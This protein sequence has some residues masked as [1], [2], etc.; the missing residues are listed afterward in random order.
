MGAYQIVRRFPGGGSSDLYLASSSG[1]R[2][3]CLLKTIAPARGDTDGILREGGILLRLSHPNVVRALE[4]GRADDTL[5]LALEHV[6][7]KDLAAVA[8]R[9]KAQGRVLS[10]PA[11]LAIVAS[12]CR[13]LAHVH[14][15][16]F[17]HRDVAPSNLLLAYDGETK[18]CDFGLSTTVTDPE[19][20]RRLI[21]HLGYLAP[22]I[23]RGEAVSPRSDLF[24]V[25]A[26][27]WELLT[28]QSRLP[29]VSARDVTRFARLRNPRFIAPSSLRSEVPAALDR[30][31]H[32][33]LAPHPK[34]RYDD[35]LALLQALEHAVEGQIGL[36]DTTSVAIAM[37]TLFEEERV[38]ESR[39]LEALRAA[40]GKPRPRAPSLVTSERRDA[41]SAAR[42]LGEVLD[43]RYR[44]ESVLGIGGMGTVYR[45]RHLG[46][47]RLVA[48]KIMHPHLALDARLVHRFDREARVSTRVCHPSFVDVFDVG[49]T[50]AGEPYL[51]MELVTGRTLASLLELE[52]PLSFEQAVRV[53]MSISA[54][55]AAAHRTGLI[56]RDLKPDNVM[57]GEGDD[58]RVLDFGICKHLD[59]GSHPTTPGVAMGSPAYMAP[60]QLDG[61]DTGAAQDIYALGCVLFEMLTGRP[62]FSGSDDVDLLTRKA[63][64]TAPSLDAFRPGL[65]TALVSLVRTCLRARPDARPTTMAEVMQV[66]GTLDGQVETDQADILVLP[67]RRVA[68]HG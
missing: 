45:A 23:A 13:A 41:S 62:P 2:E 39:E 5:F 54:A 38:A 6:H 29:R 36:E 35:L 18:L 40:A 32:R 44:V 24:S 52:G 61:T 30:V 17:I 4:V 66:L 57:V 46:L 8:A 33:A 49:R 53:A 1:S 56:H 16:G 37:S 31:L 64:E 63:T 43:A 60:E 42:R 9:A 3:V 10:I 22:E 15:R 65:P 25:A 20:N 34:D 28:G 67:T 19:P 14:Q 12:C 7:G 11:A 47:D 55:L 50:P 27:A 26:I 51:A 58:V 48:V 68:R 59:S 21:G